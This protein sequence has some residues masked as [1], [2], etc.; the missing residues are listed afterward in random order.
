MTVR[1][2]QRDQNLLFKKMNDE[3]YIKQE[4]MCEMERLKE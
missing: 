3:F 4:L 1:D 2:K